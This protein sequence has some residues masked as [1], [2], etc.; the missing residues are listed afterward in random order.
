MNI[1]QHNVTKTLNG[2]LRGTGLHEMTEY[3]AGVM[4]LYFLER[5]RELEHEY[6]LS[7][8]EKFRLMPAT[9]LRN[10]LMVTNILMSEI[11]DLLFMMRGVESIYCLKRRNY[12]EDRK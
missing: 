1:A 12:H 11:L 4:I 6:L 2:F 10:L 7:T 5:H 3:E 9:Y 8:A